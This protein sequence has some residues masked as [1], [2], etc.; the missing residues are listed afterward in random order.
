MEDRLEWMEETM[1]YMADRYPDLT[2]LELGQLDVV[3]RRFVKPAIPHGAHA[4]A[5]NRERWEAPSDE[6]DMPTEDAATPAAEPLLV[7][8]V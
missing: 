5:G 1:D 4:H 7:G 6:A 3:C 8:A 2:E